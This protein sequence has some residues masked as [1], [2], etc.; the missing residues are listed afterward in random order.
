MKNEPS[1]L[2]AIAHSALTV[3]RSP[4]AFRSVAERDD[5]LRTI[6]DKLPN[7]FFFRV[8]HESDG[9]FRFTYISSGCKEVTGLCPERLFGRATELTDLIIDDDREGFWAAMSRALGPEAS[10]DYVVR[11]RRPDGQLRWC[12]FRSGVRPGDNGAS[13][14]EGIILDIT[15]RRRV[16]AALCD[17]TARNEA[18]LAALPDLMFVMSRDGRYLDYHAR[19]SKDLLLPPE[20]FLGKQMAEV[21]PPD[22][23]KPFQDAF[24][25]VFNAGGSAVVDYA[26][27]INGERHYYEARVVGY[28]PDKFLSIIRDIS[29]SKHAHDEA[30]VNR[31]ELARVSRMTML[32]EIAASLAHELNQPLAAILNNS[33]AAQRLMT[34]GRARPDDTMQILTDIADD[35]QRAGEVIW[36]LRGLLSREESA[37]QPL[38]MNQVVHDVLHLLRSELITRRAR[39]TMAL[40]D[41]LPDVVADRIQLQQVLL[42]LALNALDA[43]SE[44]ETADRHMVIATRC[45]GRFVQVDVR[46]HGPGIAHEHLGRLFD[47]FFT[48]KPSGLGMGLRIC[49]SI[50]RSHGGRIWASNNAD[51]G[52]TFSF[53]VPVPPAA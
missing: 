16:E 2:H 8:V 6:G 27:D 21:L 24:D 23:V 42:N 50:V 52:A 47:P 51:A 33:Q 31:Q 7:A 35:C 9:S 25:Q 11:V 26:L 32:G 19:D 13:I 18:I 46:D 10:L 44:H 34:T 29:E 41:S 38:S 40:G 48:T 4:E 14:C 12:H 22:L 1:G 49:S 39:M 5:F 3:S 37:R 43:M 53:T 15:D 17:S 45:P 36:R 28:G 20:A 30:E